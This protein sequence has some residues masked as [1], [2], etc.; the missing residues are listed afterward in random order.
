MKSMFYRLRFVHL[1]F[2]LVLI[3]AVTSAPVV[4]AGLVSGSPATQ[5]PSHA[6]LYT[7]KKNKH[8]VGH[9]YV[10]SEELTPEKAKE[11][12]AEYIKEVTSTPG[13][14][15][16]HIYFTPPLVVPRPE[17]KLSGTEAGVKEEQES[18]LEVLMRAQSQDDVHWDKAKKVASLL[19]D[20]PLEPGVKSFSYRVDWVYDTP[21]KRNGCLVHDDSLFAQDNV[22]LPW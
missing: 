9:E 8:L 19:Y 10:Y 20:K 15:Q 17:A 14:I 12:F 11:E 6:E 2:G 3:G 21:P 1:I 13:Y 7:P 16:G 4:D 22:K 18:M 5:D